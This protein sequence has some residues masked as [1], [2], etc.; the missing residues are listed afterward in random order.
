MAT[1][2]NIPISVTDLFFPEFPIYIL[3]SYQC[4]STYSFSHIHSLYKQKSIFF[5]ELAQYLLNNIKDERCKS[6]IQ[7]LPKM[8]SVVVQI[9][10]RWKGR[11]V[12]R[13]YT[14]LCKIWKPIYV[15]ENCK[16]WKIYFEK[17]HLTVIQQVRRC[18]YLKG[19]QHLLDTVQTWLTPWHWWIKKSINVTQL[20]ITLANLSTGYSIKE[21]HLKCVPVFSFSH[22]HFQRF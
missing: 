8:G 3:H 12:G 15:D 14:Y 9:E 20:C 2:Q 6:K 16:M 18:T 1:N 19:I 13:I 5:N 21:V 10:I 22:V 11:K 7:I 4:C 17:N